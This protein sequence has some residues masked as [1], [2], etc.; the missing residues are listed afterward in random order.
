LINE[1]QKRVYEAF[2][3]KLECEII[4]L[5]IQAKTLF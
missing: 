4:L 1:A 2:G 5:D 3:I